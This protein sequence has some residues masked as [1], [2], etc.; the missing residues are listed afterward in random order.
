M[1]K[2]LP[3]LAL[4]FSALTA[5]AAAKLPYSSQKYIMGAGSVYSRDTVLGSTARLAFPDVTLDTVAALLDE[6]YVFGA[7][8]CGTSCPRYPMQAKDVIVCRDP[9]SGEI[10]MIAGV[11]VVVDGG[12]TKAVSFELTN[13]LGGVYARGSCAQYVSGSQPDFTFMEDNG[14]GGVAYSVDNGSGV[15][16]GTVAA[17][18]GGGYGICG[19]TLAK[20]VRADEPILMWENA[21]G[22]PVLTVEDLKDC[23]FSASFCG[24]SISREC[25]GAAVAGYNKKVETDGSGAATSIRVEFQMAEGEHVKCALVEFTNGARGVCAKQL[26]SIY[27]TGAELGHKFVADDGTY[28]VTGN[29]TPGFY[30]FRG[31]FNGYGVFALCAFPQGK[32]AVYRAPNL[33]GSSHN[34][35]DPPQLPILT[36][37]WVRFFK[38]GTIEELASRYVLSA[39]MAGASVATK[40]IA[41]ASEFHTYTPA[42]AEAATKAVCSFVFYDDV[43][44]K[45]A[46]VEFEARS[47]G[48]W[49]RYG[50]GQYLNKKKNLSFSFASFD[51]DG[52]IVYACNVSGSGASNGGGAPLSWDHG[53]YA[54]A[55]LKAVRF[56]RTDESC[57]VWSAP[58]GAPTPTLDDVKDCHLGCHFNGAWIGNKEGDGIGVNRAFQLDESGS[59]TQMRVE[60]QIIDGGYLKT[61]IMEFTNGVHGVYGRALAARYTDTSAG[62]GFHFVN[63]GGSYAGTAGTVATS[64]SVNGYGICEL[65]AVPM[66]K[67]EDDLDVSGRKAALYLGP[68]VLDLNGH[69]V[70]A[71]G[72]QSDNSFYPK[73][74]NTDFAETATVRCRTPEGFNFDNRN[75]RFGTDLNSTHNIRFVKDGAGAYGALLGQT[76][77]GGTE[78]AAGT[79]RVG[80]LGS[81][82]PLG[83][84]AKIVNIGADAALDMNGM[85]DYPQYSFV[86]D[87][88]EIRNTGSG[89]ADYQAQL[90]NVKIEADS[91]FAFHDNYG[92]IGN[93]YSDATLDL[94]GNTLSVQAEGVFYLFNVN[95]T[96]GR[97]EVAGAGV[98][99][100]GNSSATRGV[101]A[102]GVDFTVDCAL[103]VAAPLSMHDYEAVYSGDVNS[104]AAAFTVC[105]TFRPSAA[106]DRF[107]GCTL[108]NGAMLDLSA[109]TTA[110]PIASAFETGD[111]TLKFADGATVNVKLGKARSPLVSWTTEPEN[112]RSVK[113]KCANE[114]SRCSII[115]KSDGLYAVTGLAVFVR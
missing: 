91:S 105:G 98:I 36:G 81:W 11:F 97:L 77:T 79:V 62:I 69:T 73:I 7:T 13:G 113:F 86:I 67:L 103:D 57:L 9:A 71:D 45:C 22:E 35:A 5:P 75:V 104:G 3:V 68:M 17:F 6:G 101:S 26:A 1:K 27:K 31:I 41:N 53:G 109:R 32:T 107:H 18:E 33:L 43:H 70:T 39:Y 50:K 54:V 72:V 108:L 59:A 92:F 52:N 88:G 84:T 58:E 47:D 94:G 64:S 15:N 28:D 24:A 10:S 34:V 112:I 60:Y 55:G 102:A 99:S 95:M 25:L 20:V 40:Q 82:L 2:L 100:T 51:D 111:N 8:Q 89:T 61:V 56:M 21:S 114:G 49:A 85:Y 74:I 110:L 37:T 44:T 23:D 12:W 19:L 83:V 29:S 65:Y 96:A 48:V 4:A 115:A 42:D 78:I 14:S 106:H 30:G 93:G 46:C 90:K 38:G 66:M 76:Y 87:G 16:R 80:K 63:E